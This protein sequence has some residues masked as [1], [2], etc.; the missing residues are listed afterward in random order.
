V[1]KVAV[2]G[3]GAVGLRV[4]KHLLTPRIGGVANLVDRVILCDT[5]GE[6][7]IA[8]RS[9]LDQWADCIESQER[10]FPKDADVDAIVVATPRGTQA[11][12]VRTA[13]SSGVPIVL[14][15]DGLAET[16]SVLK[17][18]D[19]AALV[20]V[21]VVLGAGFSP[22][23]S[24]VL[25]AHASSWFDRVEEIHVTKVGAGGPACAL[26]H[27][28]ALSRL[29]YDWR[30]NGWV[31][32]PGGSGRELCWFPEPVGP[33]D[34]FRAALPDPVLLHHAFPNVQRITARM[35]A[36]RRDRLTAP[37]PMLSPPPVEGGIGAI[38]VEIRGQR[39]ISQDVKILGAAEKPAVAAALVAATAVDWVLAG[40]LQVSGMGSL[41][42]M[43]EP[44]GFLTDLSDRG[45][46]VEIFE[47]EHAIF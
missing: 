45:L 44:V 6:R 1:S 31:R 24:C 18:A 23:L 5:S 34:C 25:A 4:V 43:V 8:I 38:R 33:M 40:R 29:S 21:P 42:E 14:S 27:H 32:R 16:V 41:A 2:L 10:A 7:L 13:I 47:G 46:V 9:I 39:G 19:E 36:T 26:V 3:A 28:R 30:N 37:F 12:L 22:G 35:G 17:L 15:G 11:P 20:G